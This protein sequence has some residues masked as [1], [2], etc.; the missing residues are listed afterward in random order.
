MGKVLYIVRHGETELNKNGIVQGRGINSDL[1]ETGV[2]QAEAFYQYYKKVPFDKVYTS[3]LIRTQQTVRPFTESGIPTQQLSGLD[4]LAWG[5]WEGQASSA[6]SLLFFRNLLEKWQARDYEAK[7]KDGESPKEVA[8]R[9]LKAMEVIMSHPD[10]KTV[11]I[12][13][14]GRAM[15]LLLCLLTQKPIC[16]MVKFPH[17]NTSLYKL[18]FTGVKFLIKD[19]NNTDHLKVKLP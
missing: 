17:K 19:F 10:E 7:S 4:E 5:E 14:H 6:E 8:V 11:L 12:C 13:M 1:N 3:S 9:L 2:T 18:D 16:A 15:R